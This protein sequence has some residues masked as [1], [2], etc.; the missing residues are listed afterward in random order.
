MDLGREFPLA[1][2]RRVSAEPDDELERTLS[3]LQLAEFNY[4]QPAMGDISQPP[5]CRNRPS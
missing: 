1:L 2:L 3:V 4:E 5:P